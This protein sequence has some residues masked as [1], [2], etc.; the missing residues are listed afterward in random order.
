MSLILSILIMTAVAVAIRTPLKTFPLL[1]YAL[2]LLVSVAGLY[3]TLVPSPSPLI[4]AFAFALQKGH[5]GFSLFALVM[6]I[7]VFA[8]DSA[9]RR[10]FNPVRAELSILAAILIAG[11]FALYLRNY[12]LLAGDLLSLNLNI[13]S[14]LVLALVLMVLL[15]VLTVTSFNAV[16]RS[17]KA[18]TWKAVQKLAY[19]F[20]GI[21]YFHLLGYLL[22]TALSGSVSAQLNLC[23]YSVIFVAYAALRI[24]KALRDREAS[25]RGGESS[26][27]G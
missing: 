23:A 3:C 14:S 21:V 26:E 20:F 27:R 6:F 4:R 25:E 16:K 19:P 5:L 13:Q 24:R 17:M 22:P 11:H 8:N 1:F 18:S 2:A 9:I 12:L 10:Y 7:G 15:V